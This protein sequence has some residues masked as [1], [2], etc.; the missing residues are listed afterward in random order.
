ME[1]VWQQLTKG[2]RHLILGNDLF[3]LHVVCEMTWESFRT[4]SSSIYFSF[5]VTSIHTLIDPKV[6]RHFWVFDVFGRGID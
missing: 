2:H 1:I 5:C 6:N 3:S 4:I